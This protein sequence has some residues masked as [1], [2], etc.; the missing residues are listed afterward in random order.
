M[1]TS[2]FRTASIGALALVGAFPTLAAAQQRGAATAAAAATVDEVIVTATKTSES[3]SKV[4]IALSVYSGDDLVKSG[5]TNLTNLQNMAPSLNVGSASHGVSITLRGITTTDVTSKGDQSVVFS[6]DSIPIGRPQL[7]GLSFFDLERVEVLRGPQGTLYGKSS[8]GGA[9][10]VISAK[11]KNEFGASAVLEGGSYNTRRATG[12]VNLPLTDNFAVRIAANMN[13]RDGFLTPTLGKKQA[14]APTEMNLG[15]EDNWT[16]RVTGLYTFSDAA[17]LTLTGTFGHVGAIGTANA[18]WPRAVNAKGKQRFDV[19][20]NPMVG[21]LGDNDTFANYNAEFNADFGAVHLTYDG[22]HM[23]WR[24]FDNGDPLTQDPAG[25][26]GIPAYTWTQ[27]GSHLVTDSHEV[28]LSNR[29]P[30]KLDWVVGANYY[31]EDNNETD[32]NWQTLDNGANCVAPTL[33]AACSNPNP[34][35]VGLTRHKAE[36]VFGQVNYH[37]SDKLKITLGA[38]Y[39]DDSMFRHADLAVGAPPPGG[40]IDKAGKPCA[41]PNAC[42]GVVSLH[43]FGAQAAKKLTWRIGA[44]Y[45][46]TDT[47]MI[48]GS[49]ATGY[50]AGGFNDFDPKVKGTAPYGPEDLTAYEVGYKGRPLPSLR[51]STSA[52]YYDYKDYQL[53]GATFLTP[54]ATGGTLVGVIIYTT[55]AP[56]KLYGAE[57]EATWTPTANDTLGLTLSAEKGTF[58]GGKVGFIFSN[59]QDWSG[60]SLDNMPALAAT[61]NYEH[62]WTLANGGEIAARVNS[63]LSSSYKESNL[64]GNGNPFAG[65]YSV[66]PFQYTQEAYTRTDLTVGYTTPDTKYS[67]EGFVKNVEDDIQIVSSP[68]NPGVTADAQRARITSP[69]MMGVRMSLK[70]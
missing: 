66:L 45:Q 46:I 36:G 32:L 20:F 28:H 12:V 42:I 56:A 41:P 44:D 37:L 52:Y 68:G 16:A 57:A 70:Y 39:S 58:E 65:V 67:L 47:D 7:I 22:A 59:Q 55:L 35:I 50:K 19:Y 4:P 3:A 23:L 2:L 61:V 40:W 1:R 54:S 8:T 13:E 48:Y 24:G 25:G 63:K 6:I 14:T 51:L 30:G 31:V 26:G 69:R 64:G 9:I 49:V 18:I 5:V 17:S 11:P 15:G 43:D 33:A 62:R 60:K 34:H 38:R 27:Y 21:D 53:T 29:E 10:N